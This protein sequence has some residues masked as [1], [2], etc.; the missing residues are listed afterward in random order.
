MIGSSASVSGGRTG[1]L[2]QINS[3]DVNAILSSGLS[4]TVRPA[5]IP[6]HLYG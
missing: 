5:A 2:A 4:R 3:P 1:L 6:I